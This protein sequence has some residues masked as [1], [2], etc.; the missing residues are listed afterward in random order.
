[1]RAVPF[2]LALALW[3][4]SVSAAIAAE[5]APSPPDSA[6]TVFYVVRHA[7]QHPS[8]IGKDPPLSDVGKRRAQA[9][10]RVLA[11]AGIKHVYATTARRTIETGL[12]LARQIG[13]SVRT[14]EDT[15][16]LLK[17]LKAHPPGDR[18]LVVAHGNTLAE[19]IKGLTG[20]DLPPFKSGDFDMLY[21]V[22][23]VRN[24]PT[25]VLLLRY[26]EAS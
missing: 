7:E 1:M 10:A 6:V 2:G 18:V 19:I 12:P 3:A 8:M 15:G 11:D 20:R 14:I 23:V 17:Q 16:E 25:Q 4:A 22:I 26:G 21:V 5:V 24:G 13:D 9:L